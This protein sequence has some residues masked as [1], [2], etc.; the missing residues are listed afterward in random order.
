M[1]CWGYIK[2]PPLRA[3]TFRIDR[4][5]NRDHWEQGRLRERVGKGFGKKWW[6]K[7]KFGA[8]V[9][10]QLSG[11]QTLKPA[12]EYARQSHF[13]NPHTK[14]AS[15]IN[16]QHWHSQ[17]KLKLSL[18]VQRKTQGYHVDFHINSHEPCDL[19]IKWHSFVLCAQVWRSD[20]TYLS[21]RVYAYRRCTM[22]A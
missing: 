3:S 19:Y 8:L 12:L 21:D 20:P 10:V 22:Y 14:A 7:M 17:E 5:L 1:Q 2:C 4:W 18:E 11:L 15:H 13:L 6:N 16:A 9:C